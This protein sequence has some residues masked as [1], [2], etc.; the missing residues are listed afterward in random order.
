M[1]TIQDALNKAQKLH[2]EKNPVYVRVGASTTGEKP[3]NRRKLWIMLVSGG[4]VFLVLAAGSWFK[5]GAPARHA[6]TESAGSQAPASS[7]QDSYPG[8]DAGQPLD[9]TQDYSMD[10]SRP[11]LQEEGMDQPPPG[12]LENGVVEP[13][14]QALPHGM[15]LPQVPAGVQQP[16]QG[17]AGPNSVAQ[18]PVMAPES[19]MPQPQAANYASSAAKPLS[20][21]TRQGITDLYDKAVKFQ[22][23]GN[24]KEAEKYYLQC[25]QKESGNARCLN[26]LAVIYMERGD[27]KAARAKLM[28]ASQSAVDY[29]DPLY[30]LG[31]LAAREK[32]ADQAMAYLKVAIMRNQDAR[33][34]ARTDPDY[35]KFKDL[36]AFRELTG[37]AGQ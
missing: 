13:Q 28:A 21:A 6:D 22:N 30:N 33:T 9:D 1:S 7:M 5:W 17:Q 18:A 34:W 37:G 3:R 26:N 35:S 12:T 2:E 31:C 36:P 8:Y 32:N 11:D 19:P 16:P 27:Y 14:S 29:A 4:V 20:T 25:L 15:A 24:S 23:Q 10:Q